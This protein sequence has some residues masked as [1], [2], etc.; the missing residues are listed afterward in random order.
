MASSL[1]PNNHSPD[2]R[3]TILSLVEMLLRNNDTMS[4]RNVQAP[5]FEDDRDVPYHL[6]DRL[7][8]LLFLYHEN[9]ADL[10]PRKISH[11]ARETT[12]DSEAATQHR[13]IFR[14]V[15][16]KAQLHV[17]RPTVNEKLDAESFPQQFEQF[18]KEVMTFLRCLNEFPEFT[19]EA[20]NTSILSF[21]GDLKYWASCLKE[22]STQFRYPAVQRYI[23]DLSSEMGEHLDELSSSL[24]MF[25]EVGVPTIRF[26]QKHGAENLL[27]LSTV[28]T[29]FSAVTATTM[30]FSFELEHTTVA[31]SPFSWPQSA[32]V[33]VNLDKTFSAVSIIIKARVTSLITSVLT[34]FTSFGLAAVS[35]WFASERWAFT[36]HRGQKWLS[37]VLS[38]AVDAFFQLKAIRCLLKIKD[39]A[40]RHFGKLRKFILRM[41]ADIMASVAACN[42]KKHKGDVEANGHPP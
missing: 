27:N 35:A 37:D 30:Q 23:H 36:R 13:K 9:A 6:R 31:D 39:L 11:I 28:A 32:V 33:G 3:E 8:Q 2:R 21:E 38:E 42:A 29:F 40:F 22:Y 20:V 12:E 7:A 41:C 1:S 25:I 14:R 17:P 26:A 18:S 15:R 4:P 19:D 34:A 10:F 24:S 5:S 16:G